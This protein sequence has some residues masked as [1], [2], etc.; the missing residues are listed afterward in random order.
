MS[1]SLVPIIVEV[2]TTLLFCAVLIYLRKSMTPKTVAAWILL[3]VARGAISLSLMRFVGGADRLVF[4]LYAPLQIAFAMALVIIAVRLESQK[5]QLRSLNEELSRLRKD[6]EGQLDL[7][8]LTGLHNRSALARWMGEQ[9]D[10]EGL[11]VVCDM[12]DFKQ[13]NDRLGHLVGDEILHGVGKLIRSSIRDEDRAF[14]WGGDEF[15]IF[16]HT[17]D[18][19][20]V[21]GR[22]RKIEEHLGS[23]RIRQHGALPVHFS[24]GVT[25]TVGRPLREGVEEADRLM[26]EAKR[27]RSGRAATTQPGQ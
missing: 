4:L 15:V 23:F 24:W 19:D 11:V 6:A 12:D 14:R 20:L 13:I 7:D 10:F 25:P 16:F 8:P 22:L 17:L 27:T 3:W 9:K 5:Q 1:S 26:Y 18:T 2:C 21:E